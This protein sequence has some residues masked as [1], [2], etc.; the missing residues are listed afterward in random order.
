MVAVI[1][2]YKR[3]RYAFM[4]RHHSVIKVFYVSNTLQE[5][6]DKLARFK[7]RAKESNK[8]ELWKLYDGMLFHD[9]GELPQ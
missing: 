2:A 6:K 5:A 4:L 8:V 7:K 3:I 1:L 9:I